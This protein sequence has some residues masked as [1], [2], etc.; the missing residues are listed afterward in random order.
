MGKTG[1]AGEVV[2]SPDSNGRYLEHQTINLQGATDGW[3][4]KIVEGVTK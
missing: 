2:D 1:L 4:L 3:Q